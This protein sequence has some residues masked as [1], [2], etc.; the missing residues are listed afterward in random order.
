MTAEAAGMQ[1]EES[2]NLKDAAREEETTWNTGEVSKRKSQKTQKIP[3]FFFSLI[4]RHSN[5]FK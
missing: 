3:G 1:G 4:F 5:I 2:R